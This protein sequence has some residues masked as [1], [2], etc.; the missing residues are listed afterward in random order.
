MAH[1]RKMQK[2]IR[3]L[4]PKF[5]KIRKENERIIKELKSSF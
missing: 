3:K 2:A 1:K 5:K 4:S